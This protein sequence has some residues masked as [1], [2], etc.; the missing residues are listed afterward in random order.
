MVC[1][2]EKIIKKY[3]FLTSKTE[4][5]KK[6]VKEV[7]FGYLELAK[8]SKMRNSRSETTLPKKG[9]HLKRCNMNLGVFMVGRWFLDLPQY[10][11]DK[12]LR[13]IR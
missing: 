6:R 8:A 5:R 3:C 11:E 1:L 4:K 2:I 7:F 9:Q 10:G 12:I 13:E